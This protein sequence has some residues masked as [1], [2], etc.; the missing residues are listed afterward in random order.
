MIR[1]SGPPIGNLNFRDVAGNNNDID[2]IDNM[3]TLVEE[4]TATGLLNKFNYY[5]SVNMINTEAM[6]SQTQIYDG[7]NKRLSLLNGVP[8]YAPANNTFKSTN[9]KAPYSG[10]DQ[11]PT[12]DDLR[13]I[14]KVKVEIAGDWPALSGGGQR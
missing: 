12:V 5:K 8:P 13:K 6:W 7:L 14:K 3:D 2:R 9:P 10:P 4:K 1:F 11:L